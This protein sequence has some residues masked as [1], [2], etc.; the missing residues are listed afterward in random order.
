MV[1]KGVKGFMDM[2]FEKGNILN[3]KQDGITT[4]TWYRRE[5]N[6]HNDQQT[7]MNKKGTWHEWV[8]S[9]NEYKVS[10]GHLTW[11]NKT[12]KSLNSQSRKVVKLLSSVVQQSC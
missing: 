9:R 2:N 7:Y 8:M 1:E 10:H 6:K 3:T 4:F 12:C 11:Y 5:H